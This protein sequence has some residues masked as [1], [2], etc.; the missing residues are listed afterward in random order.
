MDEYGSIP[1]LREQGGPIGEAVGKLVDATYQD[2][3]LDP[4]TREL[5]YI[6]IHSAVHWTPGIIAHIERAL[7]AGCTR[8]EIVDAIMLATVNGGVNGP[9]A[10]LPAALREIEAASERIARDGP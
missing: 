5:V 6:G 9:I 7:R 3:V 4:R 2:S 10:A 8:E 1:F